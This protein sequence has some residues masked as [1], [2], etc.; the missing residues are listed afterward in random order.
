MVICL[1]KNIWWLP[2]TLRSSFL[3]MALVTLFIFTIVTAVFNV[4]I[5]RSSKSLLHQTCLMMSVKDFWM[6]LSSLLVM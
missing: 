4:V 2:V 3:E 1:L 6:M 5:K